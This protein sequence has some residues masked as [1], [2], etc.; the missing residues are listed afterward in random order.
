[1]FF[2]SGREKSDWQAVAAIPPTPDFLPGG[3]VGPRVGGLWVVLVVGLVSCS[4]S[5]AALAWSNGTGV[6]SLAQV[7]G[8]GAVRRWLLWWLGALVMRPLSAAS[9]APTAA[10][11]Q[12]RPRS[13]GDCRGSPPSF[14]TER[15]QG[16]GRKDFGPGQ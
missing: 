13:A 7:G 11:P 9:P 8:W 1:M 15:A 12:R 5:A 6:K 2:T 10:R 16:I 14:D 3:W 4:S